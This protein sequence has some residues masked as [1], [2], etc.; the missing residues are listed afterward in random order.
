MVC[1]V[2]NANGLKQE[3]LLVK[4]LKSELPQLKSVIINSNREKTN[5]VLGR[6]NRTIYGSDHITDTLCGLQFK[7]SPFSFWQINRKQAEKLYGKAKEY[8]NLKSDEIL[9]DLYCGTG[10]I[11]LTMADSCKQLIG[12]EIVEDAVKDANENAKANGIENARFICGDASDAAFQLEKEALKPDCVI[13]DPPRK[14]CGEELVKTISRM[15]PS[16]VVYVSCDPATLARDL[17]FFTENG[18]TPKEITP[19]DMFS[20]TSHVESVALIERN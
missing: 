17:K 12:A 18:Y 6:K 13:L 3:D 9:L 20:G 1:Y 15:S 10:T 4:M 11:G 7:I 19:C 2:V 16:R 14:G 5:V 8:A